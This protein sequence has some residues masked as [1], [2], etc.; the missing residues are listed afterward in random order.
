MFILFLQLHQVGY[1][2]IWGYPTQIIY[3]NITYIGELFGKF[4]AGFECRLK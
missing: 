4:G 1:P 2:H 3:A